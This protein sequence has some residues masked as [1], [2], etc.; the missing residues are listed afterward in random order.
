MNSF[1]FSFELCDIKRLDGNTIEYQ[2]NVGYDLNLD[3][4]FVTK[5][6]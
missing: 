1:F 4:T 5:L 3:V 2:D 6:L